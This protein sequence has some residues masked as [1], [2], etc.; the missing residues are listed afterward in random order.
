MSSNYVKTSLLW[1]GW[2]F[3]WFYDLLRLR[4]VISVFCLMRNLSNL[5]F[6]TLIWFNDELFIFVLQLCYRSRHYI[7]FLLW[8]LLL[9]IRLAFFLAFLP[10]LI[11]A[12]P[13]LM[14]I[15]TY[16]NTLSHWVCLRGC[17]WFTLGRTHLSIFMEFIWSKRCWLAFI[18]LVIGVNINILFFLRLQ[19]IISLSLSRF[20]PTG[21]ES[22][23]LGW[24]GGFI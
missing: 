6:I 3:R 2:G 16:E 9:Y 20:R 22:L 10:K 13:V 21:I 18:Q 4:F 1:F 5:R 19:K 11:L 17:H 14:L 8:W 7:S 24:L 12:R 15:S 23:S